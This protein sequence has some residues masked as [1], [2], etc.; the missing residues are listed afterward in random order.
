MLERILKDVQIFI[1]CPE[2]RRHIAASWGWRIVGWSAFA[3]VFPVAAP[4][5]LLHEAADWAAENEIFLF[6]ARFIGG[7]TAGRA[8]DRKA[9]AIREAH[10][11]LT[12]D[13]IRSRLAARRRATK[14]GDGGDG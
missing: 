3:V 2:I 11:V 1:V 5:W 4:F 13:D 10:E 14:D 6:P 8:M 9:A 7:N 12:P